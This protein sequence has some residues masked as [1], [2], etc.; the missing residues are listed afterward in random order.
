M[1]E[2]L[3]EVSVRVSYQ[4]NV[5]W[6]ELEDFLSRHIELKSSSNC[7][8]PSPCRSS[9]EAGQ[10]PFPRDRKRAKKQTNTKAK[11]TEIKRGKSDLTYITDMCH[12]FAKRTTSTYESKAMCFQMKSKHKCL[13]EISILIKTN[14]SSVCWDSLIIFMSLIYCDILHSRLSVWLETN[15]L[16]KKKE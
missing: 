15:P 14:S 4:G 5:I 3:G 2:S 8:R 11:K 1:G 9:R 12:V 16:N 10:S 6:S 13:K 7:C